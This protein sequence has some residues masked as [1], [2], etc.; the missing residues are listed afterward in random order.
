[1]RKVWAMALLVALMVWVA[2]GVPRALAKPMLGEGKVITLEGADDTFKTADHYARQYLFY[3]IAI[4]LGL[5]G[6]GTMPR[7]MGGGLGLLGGGGVAGLYPAIVGSSTAQAQAMVG[8][9]ISGAPMWLAHGPQ[10][11]GYVVPVMMGA[12]AYVTFKRCKRR[13]A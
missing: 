1:M 5:A 2:A 7:S 13:A 8:L 12:S 10:L 6:F 4:I 9:I 11:L 3:G